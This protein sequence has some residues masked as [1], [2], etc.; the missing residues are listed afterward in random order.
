MTQSSS[1]VP[2][3]DDL[4]FVVAPAGERGNS[5]PAAMKSE[6]QCEGQHP[7]VCTVSQCLPREA[8]AAPGAATH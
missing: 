5:G 8:L 6:D 3:A 1:L 2:I 4:A 7:P